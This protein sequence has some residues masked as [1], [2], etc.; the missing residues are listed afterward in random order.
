MSEALWAARQGDALDHSSLLADVLGGVLEVAAQV[1]VFALSRAAIIAAVGL[2]V[3]TG[4]I[5]ALVLCAV[6]GVVVG[7][8]IGASGLQDFPDMKR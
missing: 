3:V 5:G 7:V 8:G 1:A 6:V 2:V 4:P